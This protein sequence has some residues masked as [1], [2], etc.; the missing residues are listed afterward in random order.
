MVKRSVV[1]LGILGLVY[2][3]AAPAAHGA[4]TVLWQPDLST[5]K[6]VGPMVGGKEAAIYTQGVNDATKGADDTTKN[7]P[8]IKP[9]VVITDTNAA[10]E[11]DNTC[12]CDKAKGWLDAGD[13]DGTTTHDLSDDPT[14]KT[15]PDTLLTGDPTWA[16]V[17]IQAKL[18]NLNQNTGTAG[19][20]LRAAP[21]TKPEDPDSYYELRY[22]SDGGAVLDAEARDGIEPCMDTNTDPD[23]T[24]RP[25]CLRIMKVVKGSWKMLKEQGAATSSVYIPRLNRLGVDHDVNKDASD[26]GN[27]TD[28]LAGGYLRFEAK[29]NVLTGYVSMDGKKFDQVLQVT[30]DDL[31]AGLVGFTG[32]DWHPLWKEILVETLP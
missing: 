19:L 25:I 21:K 7:N 15:Y 17:A 24:A 5:G 14:E 9:F 32:Y 26:D 23:G 31:K 11:F 8:G 30:D 1:A 18:D 22:V 13:A 20:V 27:G 12:A 29:G 10:D 3:L 16:D 2:A 4:A 6:L 28:A